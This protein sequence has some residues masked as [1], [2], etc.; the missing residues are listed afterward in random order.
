MCLWFANV[1][2]A[3]DLAEE[4]LLVESVCPALLTLAEGLQELLFAIISPAFYWNF[5][6]SNKRLIRI[7][8]YVNIKTLYDV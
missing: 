1:V 7:S 8:W 3:L 6:A 4:D 5:E 2:P